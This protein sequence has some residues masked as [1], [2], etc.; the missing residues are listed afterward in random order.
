MDR[1][2][3]RGIVPRR[4]NAKS[5]RVEATKLPLKHLQQRDQRDGQNQS[6]QPS[7]VRAL[8]ESNGRGEALAQQAL[9]RRDVGN[10]SD[11]QNVKSRADQQRHRNGLEKISAAEIRDAPLQPPWERIRSRS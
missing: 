5:S 7:G 6:N 4:P 1:E 3:T 2:K 8:L 11:R 9:P 10:G